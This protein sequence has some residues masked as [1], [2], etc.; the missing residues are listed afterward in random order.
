MA[1]SKKSLGLVVYLLASS[2]SWCLYVICLILTCNEIYDGWAIEDWFLSSYY[3]T[4]MHCSPRQHDTHQYK[5]YSRQAW[6]VYRCH[7]VY[8][9]QW[10]NCAYIVE[11]GICLFYWL[12]LYCQ[13][14]CAV[15]LSVSNTVLPL[16]LGEQL[17]W[18]MVVDVH[19]HI[20]IKPAGIECDVLNTINKE[21]EVNY[22]C[23]QCMLFVWSCLPN[24]QLNLLVVQEC[25][26]YLLH[27]WDNGGKFISLAIKI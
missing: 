18:C 23:Y 24:Y 2:C 22:Y 13:L 6:N 25:H 12:Q 9:V 14:A 10:L 19:S 26:C 17:P 16:L 1:G 5:Y 11:L 7:C 27:I 20:G 8:L 15:W 3:T 21:K 4:V